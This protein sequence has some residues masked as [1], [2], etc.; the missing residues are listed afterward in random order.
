M[1]KF[2]GISNFQAPQVK[3]AQATTSTTQ[4]EYG[5]PYA[6]EIH[7]HTN[8]NLT[9]AVPP[10]REDAIRASDEERELNPDEL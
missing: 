4:V 6:E 5:T 3:Q 9:T 2:S 10:D 1:K 8:V 7:E